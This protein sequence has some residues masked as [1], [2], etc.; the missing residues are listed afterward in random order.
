MI[1]AD[2]GSRQRGLHQTGVAAGD[3]EK[4]EGR[5]EDVVQGCSKDSP[6]F[7]VSQATAFDQLAVSLP[8]FL[9][10]GQRGGVHDRAA[11]LKLVNMNVYQGRCLLSKKV[12]PQGNVAQENPQF[13]SISLVRG[14]GR[15]RGGVIAIEIVVPP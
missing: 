9:K 12:Q 3:V 13:G 4:A 7:A 6:D 2:L 5:F 8:L 10:L 15:R 1:V 11:G 14:E